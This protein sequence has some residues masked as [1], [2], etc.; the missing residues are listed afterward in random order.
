MVDADPQRTH[1]G[2]TATERAMTSEPQRRRSARIEV[3]TTPEDRAL[4]D[5]A[6]TESDM[7]LT[8]FVVSNL[9]IAAH[10]VLADRTEFVLD[11]ESEQAWEMIN[12]R[13]VRDL[14]GLRELMQRPSPFVD[15]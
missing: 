13:P 3:R 4:I 8:Q 1:S 2:R 14:P 9:T 11:A 6:V 12:R 10:R 7:D 5:R 15:E